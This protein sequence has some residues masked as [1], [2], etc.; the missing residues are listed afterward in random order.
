MHGRAD[1][2]GGAR[3]RCRRAGALAAGFQPVDPKLLWLRASVA[4]T[5]S[6]DCLSLTGGL[7]DWLTG[8]DDCH[9]AGSQ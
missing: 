8:S 3:R 6:D 4:L 5:G 9:S 1:V 2:A 7:T